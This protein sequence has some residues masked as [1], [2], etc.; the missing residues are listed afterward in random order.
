MPVFVGDVVQRLLTSAES[1]ETREWQ[2]NDAI[3][4]VTNGSS[5]SRYDLTKFV[6]KQLDVPESLV[7][8]SEQPRNPEQLIRPRDL[9]LEMELPETMISGTFDMLAAVTAT[10]GRS[11]SDNLSGA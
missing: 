2:A 1:L 6:A 11:L 7:I 9:T 4:H 5:I 8:R 3:K 10:C